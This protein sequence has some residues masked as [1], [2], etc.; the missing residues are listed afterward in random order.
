MEK[1]LTDEEYNRM[2]NELDKVKYR[3]K[4]GHRVIIY[5]KRKMTLC[6]WCGSYVFKDKKD[7]FKYRMKE[8]IK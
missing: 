1:I 6:D 4:C 5:G 2:T 3:C 8:K 7:E